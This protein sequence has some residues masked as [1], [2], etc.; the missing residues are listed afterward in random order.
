VGTPLTPF[1][2]VRIFSR[3]ITILRGAESRA[4]KREDLKSDQV[5][6]CNY[7]NR[8]LDIK[9]SKNIPVRNSQ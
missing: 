8:A 9:K 3:I 2:L 5:L 4:R 1:T 6:L 7:V